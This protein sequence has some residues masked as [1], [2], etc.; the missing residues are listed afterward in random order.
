VSESTLPVKVIASARRTKTVA[1]RVVNGVIEVRVP[2]AMSAAERDRHVDTLVARVERQR[3]AN[4]V[5]LVARASALSKRF[6]LPAASSVD[7]SSRQKLRWGSC[8]PSTGA[9]RISD[10]M[11][12]FPT[13]VIDYVLVHE[14]AHL[15]EPNHSRRFHELVAAYPKA[16]KAEGFLVAVSLGHAA[17]LADAPPECVVENP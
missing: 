6:D 9:I 7:W 8:T 5:D 3:S 4:H 13:W 17:D 10:R 16:E 14:L 1:A 15:A 2:A 12:G 11:T